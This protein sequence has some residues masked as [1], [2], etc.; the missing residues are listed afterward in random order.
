[1]RRKILELALLEPVTAKA[2]AASLEV[3]TTRL[4]R[5][6]DT[7]C[8][9]GLLEVTKEVPKRG[10]VERWFQTVEK[11][12]A[13]VELKTSPEGLTRLGAAQAQIKLPI[14]GVAEFLRKAVEVA[15]PYE[16][17]EGEPMIL[18][19]SLDYKEETK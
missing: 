12:D 16:N 19:I 17:G 15:S 2:L 10:V 5:H 7:L 18:T 4:Y 8:Q 13:Y 3:P 11:A 6:L 9:V 1:L 14:E